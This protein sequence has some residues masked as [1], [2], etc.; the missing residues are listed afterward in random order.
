LIGAVSGL[1]TGVL[2]GWLTVRTAGTTGGVSVGAYTGMAFGAF[3]GLVFGIF[4]P[5]SF[6]QG[7]LALDVLILNVIFS[8]RFEAAILFSFLFSVLATAIGAW[9]GGRNLKPRDIENLKTH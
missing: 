5:E 4:L 7:V 1:V 6:R 3:L 9:I 8:G 2:T